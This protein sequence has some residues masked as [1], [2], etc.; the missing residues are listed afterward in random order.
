MCPLKDVKNGGI[1]PEIEFGFE[2]SLLSSGRN[3][4]EFISVWCDPTQIIKVTKQVA[5]CISDPLA[6]QNGMVLTS[7]KVQKSCHI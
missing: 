2:S 3:K 1:C 7:R 6:M 5:K 4:S